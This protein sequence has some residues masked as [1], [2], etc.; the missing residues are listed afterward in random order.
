MVPLLRPA[1][2]NSANID[3]A[4]IWR[5]VAF[6]VQRDGPR[7]LKLRAAYLTGWFAAC[8]MPDINHILLVP[9]WMIG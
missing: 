2:L 1:P 4:T 9:I 8:V 5:S 3:P 6:L 7:K